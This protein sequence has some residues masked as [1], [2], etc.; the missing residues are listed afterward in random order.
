MRKSNLDHETSILGVK[1]SIPSRERENMMGSSK[2]SS[3]QVCAGWRERAAK[4]SF[5]EDI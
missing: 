1:I 3:T 4:W 2:K 5:P